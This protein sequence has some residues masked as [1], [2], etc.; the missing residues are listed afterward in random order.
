MR[1]GKR[2]AAG[3]TAERTVQEAL[4]QCMQQAP[5]PFAVTRGAAHTL[6]YA[7]SAFCHLAGVASAD[8]LGAPIANAFTAT[9]RRALISILDRAFR[10]GV[11]LLDERVAASSQRA[12]GWQCSV[13]PVIAADGRAEA[14]GIEIREAKTPDAALELQRQVAE[15][16]LLGALRERGLAE[17]AEAAR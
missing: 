3:S 7:N 8:A 10:D 6:V 15:Q 14:L 12:S 2:P 13:W 4:R 17:D 11:E 1:S 16:M 9:E 5:L